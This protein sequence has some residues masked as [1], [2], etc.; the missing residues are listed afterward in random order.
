[1]LFNTG[2]ELIVSKKGLLTTVAYQLGKTQRP[3]YALEGSVA[4]AG[5]AVTW[6]RDNLRIIQ[7]PEQLCEYHYH[8]FCCFAQKT[9]LNTP[10]SLLLFPSAEF[11]GRVTHT[12]GV[13]FV[14]AF[15]GL[16]APHWRDDARGYLMK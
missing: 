7:G 4:I 2:N 15:S 12:G 9:C 13:Y 6:L 10:P 3:V 1:M 14:P 8:H 11:A 5:V 16:F